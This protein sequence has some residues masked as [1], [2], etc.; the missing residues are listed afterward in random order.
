M[1]EENKEEMGSIQDSLDEFLKK[2]AR[3]KNNLIIEKVL[4][5]QFQ[6]FFLDLCVLEE[7][8]KALD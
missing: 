7:S 2:E 8:F 4:E 6:Y 5:P 3:L 1:S